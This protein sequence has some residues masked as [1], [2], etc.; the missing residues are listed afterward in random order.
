[1]EILEGKTNNQMQEKQPVGLV[2]QPF[3]Y[4][5]TQTFNIH[6]CLQF[7]SLTVND[8]LIL[9][10]N[11]YYYFLRWRMQMISTDISLEKGSGR[12]VTSFANK[13]QKILKATVEMLWLHHRWGS[14]TPST[15]IWFYAQE[16]P[17]LPPR[18]KYN[19]LFEL[20][21]SMLLQETDKRVSSP[22]D[23]LPREPEQG[24]C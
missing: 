1:M 21:H 11:Y 22:K 16:W 7:C 8:L 19:I 3:H 4:Y 18:R 2:V 13:F 24:K 6:F 9:A 5:H 12:E 15:E 10:I 17:L 23:P 20:P 14:E